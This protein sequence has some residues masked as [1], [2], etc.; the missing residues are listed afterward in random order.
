MIRGK[1]VILVKQPVSRVAPHDDDDDNPPY[2]IAGIV[3]GM[4]LI[5]AIYFL[6]FIK[7]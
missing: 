4:V 5:S 2:F 1:G 3:L 7:K 6:L